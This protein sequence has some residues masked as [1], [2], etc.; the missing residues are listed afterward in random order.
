M[1]IKTADECAIEIN[2]IEFDC[3]VYYYHTDTCPDIDDITIERI[4]VL[5]GGN[6]YDVDFILPCTQTVEDLKHQIVVLETM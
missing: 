1:K 2:G 4:V 5:D 6:K 3:E